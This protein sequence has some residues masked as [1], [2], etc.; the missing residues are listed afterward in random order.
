MH[1]LENCKRTFNPL[2]IF[3]TTVTFKLGHKSLGLLKPH[4][5][6]HCI[7]ILS[8]KFA[9]EKNARPYNFSDPVV[10]ANRFRCLYPRI[11]SRS[12]SIFSN[13]SIAPCE[14]HFRSPVGGADDEEI[15]EWNVNN[16]KENAR[17][18]IAEITFSCRA[19]SLPCI[20]K[21]AAM[22]NGA[23]LSSTRANQ[24]RIPT[25]LALKRLHFPDGLKERRHGIYHVNDHKCRGQICKQARTFGSANSYATWYFIAGWQT[26]LVVWLSLINWCINNLIAG[27]DLISFPIRV[28]NLLKF[29][30]ERSDSRSFRHVLITRPYLFSSVNLLFSTALHL[31]VIGF[32]AYVGVGET[33]ILFG[34]HCNWHWTKRHFPRGKVVQGFI[35]DVVE[36]R[37]PG[38]Q[39]CYAKI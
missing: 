21:S 12:V 31:Y 38:V 27:Y 7:L 30:W 36:L 37:N 3:P 28:Y 14:I 29:V 20:A 1:V 9:R 15:S 22:L 34:N 35:Y 25:Q 2:R 18:G 5:A 17:L 10:R 8:D 39:L 24:T 19:L 23:R 11:F 4:H 33:L 13:G 32:F 16:E 26:A 6:W